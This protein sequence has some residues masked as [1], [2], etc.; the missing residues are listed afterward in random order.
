MSILELDASVKGADR[1]VK[2]KLI[3]HLFN[4]ETYRKSPDKLLHEEPA[5]RKAHGAK[6]GA[7]AGRTYHTR[8]V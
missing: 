1:C 7:A 3:D 4:P 2:R 6:R 5:A 8:V